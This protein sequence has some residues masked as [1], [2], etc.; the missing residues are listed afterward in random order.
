MHKST[1]NIPSYRLLAIIATTSC[2]AVSLVVLVA[3]YLAWSGAARRRALANLEAHGFFADRW[4]GSGAATEIHGDLAASAPAYPVRPN[5]IS[6]LAPGRVDTIWLSLETPERPDDSSLA[7]IGLFR[8]IRE[9]NITGHNR[10]TGAGLRHI[11]GHDRLV[12]LYLLN[13]DLR[14]EELRFLSSVKSVVRLD[15]TNQP[16]SDAGLRRL[17]DLPNIELLRLS[18]TRVTCS[19]LSEARYR[20]V[21]KTIEVADTLLDEQGCASILSLPALRYVDVSG[22]SIDHDTIAQL[23]MRGVEVESD[24]KAARTYRRWRKD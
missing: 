2:V 9:L 18:G 23:R 14:D 7:D 4:E 8:E 20:N 24:S 6:A 10:I 5:D 11:A 17:S 1:T 22:C 15:L 21:L 12:N 19:F 16:V 3:I 13:G